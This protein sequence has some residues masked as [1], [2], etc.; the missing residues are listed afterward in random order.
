MILSVCDTDVP[1]CFNILTLKTSDLMN[2][3]E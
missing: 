1:L 3:G 2:K